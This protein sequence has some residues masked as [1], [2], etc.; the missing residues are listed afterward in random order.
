MSTEDRE[1]WK[2][3]IMPRLIEA[4]ERSTPR[5]MPPTRDEWLSFIGNQC[6]E[7]AAEWAERLAEVQELKFRGLLLEWLGTPFFETEKDW[8]DWVEDFR[9][10]VLRACEDPILWREAMEAK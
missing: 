2:A 6:A 10:R 4:M 7:I 1:A 9:P 3:A 5:D 8:R